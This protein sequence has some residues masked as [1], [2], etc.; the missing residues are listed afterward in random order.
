MKGQGAHSFALEA[1]PACPACG[2]LAGTYGGCCVVCACPSLER[3]VESWRERQKVFGFMLVVQDHGE[4][5][6]TSKRWR[7][8][9]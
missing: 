7:R 2:S 8:A 4:G 5:G 1:A 3:Q 6:R 9:V